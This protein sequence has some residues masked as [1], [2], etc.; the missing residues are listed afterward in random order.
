MVFTEL[1]SLLL[2][3]AGRISLAATRKFSLHEI[4]P[5]LARSE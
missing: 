2:A 1:K 5:G 4:T 3:Q